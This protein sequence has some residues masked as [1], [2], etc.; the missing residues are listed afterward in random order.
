MTSVEQGERVV[1]PVFSCSV[2]QE[3][4]AA[5]V[6]VLG[7]ID[8]ASAAQFRTQVLSLAKEHPGRIDLHMEHTALLDAAGLAVLVELWRFSE[9]HGIPLTVRSPAAS[10]RQVFD[11]AD[12]GRLLTLRR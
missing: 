11:V 12:S 9:E 1:P 4:D 2:S 7:T 5:V 10:I 8:R 6:E 3:G